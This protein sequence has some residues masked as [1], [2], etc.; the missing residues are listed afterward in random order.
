[1]ID[2]FGA[3]VSGSASAVLDDDR[4]APFARQPVGDDPWHGIGRSAGGEGHND[5]H[6]AIWIVTGQRRR[7]T[8]TDKARAAQRRKCGRPAIAQSRALKVLPRRLV[9]LARRRLV[10]LREDSLKQ[11]ASEVFYAHRRA[12]GVRW[13]RG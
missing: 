12:N 8:C 7:A 4:L 5:F 6:G 9:R 3:D 13:S 10:F 2:L 11:A 1:M